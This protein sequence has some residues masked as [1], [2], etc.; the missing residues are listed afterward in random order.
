[1]NNPEFEF[2]CSKRIAYTSSSV[3]AES[4]ASQM[5]TAEKTPQGP[6]TQG[7]TSAENLSTS[8]KP[9]KALTRKQRQKLK[10]KA[11]RAGKSDGSAP[12]FRRARLPKLTELPDGTV[13][14]DARGLKAWEIAAFTAELGEAV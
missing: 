9:A 3:D 13:F 5:A 8:D 11:R 14:I 4:A 6:S 7:F 10:R 12:Q 2:S 1:M